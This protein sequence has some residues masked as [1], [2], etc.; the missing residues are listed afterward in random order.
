MRKEVDSVVRQRPITVED[1]SRLPYI[2]ACLREALRLHPPS[3]GFSLTPTGDELTDGP[4][5]LGGKWPVKRKQAVFIVLPGVHR[6]PDVRGP[7]ADEF[8]P[9]RML[10]QNF[11]KL[12][13]GCYKP[14]GN[15]LRGCIGILNP[16]IKL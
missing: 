5:I 6:D 10:D 8:K 1:V 9:E 11:K 3:G 13:P 15:G 16:W 4:A 14:F 2:K 7:D 12:P